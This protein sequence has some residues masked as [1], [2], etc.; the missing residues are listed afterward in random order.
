MKKDV[1]TTFEASRYLNVAPK[2]VSNWIDAGYLKAYRTVG[3][4]R[5]ISREDLEAFISA[6]QSGRRLRTAPRRNRILIVDDE[7]AVVD[8]LAQGLRQMDPPCDV[9]T[10]SSSFEAGVKVAE[11]APDLIILDVLMPGGEGADACRRIRARP[12]TRHT[13]IIAVTSEPNAALADEFIRHGANRCIAGPLDAEQIRRDVT[14]LLVG[15]D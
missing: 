2:T 15:D 3:G 1:L 11:F 9:E 7:P 8:A 6:Q 13:K 10:A 4:H 14:S 12:D 5:R